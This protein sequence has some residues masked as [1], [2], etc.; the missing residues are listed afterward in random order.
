MRAP[1]TNEAIHILK[2]KCG[3][4]PFAKLRTS[5]GLPYVEFS[6]GEGLVPSHNI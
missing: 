6:V 1:P 2:I 4:P 3:R 5:K